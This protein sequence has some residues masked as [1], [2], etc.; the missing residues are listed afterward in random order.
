MAIWSDNAVDN[1]EIEGASRSE[2]ARKASKKYRKRWGEPHCRG[3]EV[4]G[5]SSGSL[6]C[7]HDGKKK[8]SKHTS[9]ATT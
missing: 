5:K 2:G 4:S 3:S 8:R 9:V 6:L 1:I 7:L